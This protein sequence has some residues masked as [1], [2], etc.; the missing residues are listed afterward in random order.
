MKNY[1]INNDEYYA[2]VSIN[3]RI[4]PLDVVYSASY[5]FTD[6]CY[7]VIDGNPETELIVYI[8]PK[9]V[10]Q[11]LDKA[12]NEFNNELL[13][14]A[15]Y[16][17][18]LQQNARLR[19]ILL[20]RILMAGQNTANPNSNLDNESKPWKKNEPISNTEEGN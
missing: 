5:L 9:E 12:A 15:N 18:Q 16:N 13:N 3:P 1:Q 20:Q 8:K 4:Y 19:E 6:K 2:A 10:G 7:I 14:Y 11:D 17:A